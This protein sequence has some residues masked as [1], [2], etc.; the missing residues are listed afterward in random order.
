MC[1]TTA[2]LEENENRLAVLNAE[3]DS[4]KRGISAKEAQ[5]DASNPDVFHTLQLAM[6]EEA[7]SVKAQL[8]ALKASCR[9]RSVQRWKR[10]R[11]DRE[12]ELGK[13]LQ[14]NHTILKQD[15]QFAAT[16]QAMM[17]ELLGAVRAHAAQV[18]GEFTAD[19]EA[20]VSQRG[21]AEEEA[22]LGRKTAEVRSLDGRASTLE[23]RVDGL[24]RRLESLGRQREELVDRWKAAKEASHSPVPEVSARDVLEMDERLEIAQVRRVSKALLIFCRLTRHALSLTFVCPQH[25]QGL[26]GWRLEGAADSLAGLSSGEV[27]LRFGSLARLKLEL[28]SNSDDPKLQPCVNGVLELPPPGVSSGLQ[29]EQLAVAARFLCAGARLPLPAFPLP[30]ES[31]DV[32]S[33]VGRWKFDDTITSLTFFQELSASVSRLQCFLQDIG[34]LRLQVP[35]LTGAKLSS[36][37]G[38]LELR[39]M[40]FDAGCLFT[41][42]VAVWT[43][44]PAGPMRISAR[45]QLPGKHGLTA[46][47]IESAANQVPEQYGRVQKLCLALGDLASGGQ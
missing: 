23:R 11:A 14:E 27:T 35:A 25:L 28:A 18:R 46:Q 39:F 40:D 31:V 7:V 10:W 47:V 17:N 26:S 21:A 38:T 24:R 6:G 15:V 29:A 2:E 13:R 30:A 42:A 20:G 8:A 41:A 33:V 1:V 44:Y 12:L 32:G 43:S 9:A 45:V 36:D 37:G 5:L 22:A 19:R 16:N 4:R 3:V 34:S